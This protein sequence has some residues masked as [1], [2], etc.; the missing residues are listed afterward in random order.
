[1]RSFTAITLVS[2]A[3]GLSSAQAQYSINPNS[4]DLN[5]RQY[6]CQ[7]Q[8]T[9]CPLICLQTAGNSASTQAN[10]CDATTLTYDCVCSNGLAPNA[11]EYSQ[12]LPYFICS[13]Y[14][15]QCV[16]ACGQ[17]ST[18]ASNCRS[19]HP[20]GAQNPTRVNTSTI[21]MTMAST[22]SGQAGASTGASG[23]VYTGFGGSAAT[24]TAASSNSG[25]KTSGAAERLALKVGQSWGL[26]LVIASIT[27]GFALML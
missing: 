14:G 20:C 9:Q 6:W 23:V 21:S 15:N 4:V 18:C 16:K 8:I 5:T 10:D 1:M 17:D 11:T 3:I 24:S 12:T 13:E 25:G 7:S 26:G 22:T 19:Q 27:G 2:A